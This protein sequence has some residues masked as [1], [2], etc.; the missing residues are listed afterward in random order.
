[1]TFQERVERLAHY[2]RAVCGVCRALHPEYSPSSCSMPYCSP[3]HS[4]DAGVEES[5]ARQ[6]EMGNTR[7]A[8]CRAFRLYPAKFSSGSGSERIVLRIPR[9]RSP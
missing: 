5:P 8:P 1:M 2:C 6:S 4:P 7:K 9:Y 3:P